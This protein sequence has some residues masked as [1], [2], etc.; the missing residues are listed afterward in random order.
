M[1]TIVTS[2]H[3]PWQHRV[4]AAVALAVAA[5]LVAPAAPTAAK[6]FFQDMQG[7][8]VGWDDRVSSTILGCPGNESC[9]AAVEG[10]DIYLRRGARRSPPRTTRGLR[11]LGRV[12]ENGVIAFRVP[13]SPAGRYHLIAAAHVGQ[14]TGPVLAS[15]TFR[16]RQR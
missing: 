9:R 14:A 3:P 1:E 5:V 7:R 2:Y 6:V 13:R 12:T 16:I 8:V 15:G 10:T 4:L 11:G